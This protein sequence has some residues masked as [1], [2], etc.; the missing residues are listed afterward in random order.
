MKGLA[1]ARHVYIVG[2]KGVGMTALAQL[3]QTKGFM[4]EGSDVDEPFFTDAV[5][6]AHHIPVHVGF[7]AENIPNN[8]DAVL[9]STAY[10]LQHPELQEAQRRA[11]PIYTYPQILG[12]LFSDADGIAVAG[13]HGKTTTTALLGV[14]LKSA[15]LDPSVIVGSHVLDFQGNALIGTS[16]YLVAETDEYQNKFTMYKPK[17]LIITNIEYDHPDFFPSEESYVRAFSEFLEKVPPEGHLVL[18]L[19]SQHVRDLRRALSRPSV[20][21]GVSK[22]ADFCLHNCRWQGDRQY[23]TIVEK[24]EHIPATLALPGIPNA[25]NATAAAGFARAMGVEWPIIQKA[26][27]S[28]RGIARRFEWKGSYRGAPIIDDYAHHPTEIA[29]AISA[30]RQRFSK[31]RLVV[32]FQPHTYSRTKALLDEFAQ[33]L[34]AD[35]VF[36]LEV[37]AS[38]REKEATVPSREIVKKIG[39]HASARYLATQEDALAAV[40]ETLQAG[41]TLLLLG[42]GDVWRVGEQLLQEPKP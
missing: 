9:Y 42:A 13:S 20:T 28:F 33:A 31:N 34:R 39:S 16:K 22:E 4:V 37:Y 19:D 41:D 38:A 24:G 15:G 14:I 10:S 32:V 5:L 8:T 35:L 17:H 25:L 3:L 12:M 1:D 2:I 23:F 36:V 18:G 26:L 11:L 7:R 40:Q 29:A 30:A 21:F 6:S 27:S